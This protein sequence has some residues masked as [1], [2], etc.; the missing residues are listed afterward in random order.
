M[1]EL[2]SSVFG[3]GSS[4]VV[5]GVPFLNKQTKTMHRKEH[6][7]G[8]KDINTVALLLYVSSV[9]ATSVSKN[10]R[11]MISFSNILLAFKC[12]HWRRLIYAPGLV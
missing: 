6:S 8:L 4:K 5:F 7:K 2:Y 1:S 9:I 12:W 10:A 3:F 11:L